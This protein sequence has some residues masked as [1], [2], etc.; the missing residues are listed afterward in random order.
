M[1][2]KREAWLRTYLR[3]SAAL[4]IGIMPS[5]GTAMAAGAEPESGVAEVLITGTLASDDI[6]GGLRPVSATTLDPGKIDAQ[7][8]RLV[9]DILR[10]VPGVE[11]SVSVGGFTQVRMRGGESNHTLVLI[12]GIEASDP[13]AGEF[14]FP[15]LIA[16]DVARIEIL[17]GQQSALYGSD[18]IG[19]VIHYITP[20]GREAPGLRARAEGGSFGTYS[21]AARFAGYNDMIDYSISANYLHTEGFAVARGGSQEHGTENLALSGKFV[22]TPDD[23][24]TLTAVGRYSRFEGDVATQ[25]FNFPPGP[26]YGL[27]VDGSDTTQGDFFHGRLEGELALLEGDWTH[28]ISLQWVDGG[29]LNATAGATNFQSEATRRKW[30]YVTSYRFALG[31][32]VNSLTFAADSERETFQNLPVGGAPPMAMNDERVLDTT[33]LVGEYN[34]NLDDAFAVAAAFRHDWNSG[35]ED[36]STYRVGATYA[37]PMGVTFHAAYGTGF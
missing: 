5:T 31:D 26:N 24:I 36:V 11:V 23:H 14:D 10:E 19:G 28:R 25:D 3:G 15:T 8:I 16:D 32:A 1:Q 9:T 34:L 33:S 27:V 18:A 37:F 35:F 21:G 2:A 6:L 7:Q 30:V 4:I 12:D 20:L 13:F 17:R 29:R 22:V